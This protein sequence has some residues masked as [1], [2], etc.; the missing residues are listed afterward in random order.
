MTNLFFE[1]TYIKF[2]GEATT[3]WNWAYLRN[4]QCEVLYRFFWTELRNY[5]RKLF[6]C[7]LRR[8]Q[9]VL[10][11]SKRLLT[12]QDV[13]TTSGKRR[14]MCDVLKTFDLDHLEDDQFSMSWRRLIYEVLRTSDL[15]RFEITRFTSSWRRPI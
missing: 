8:L 14:R 4:Q 1:K 7:P 5:N 6:L 12:K 13:V 3:K 15:R 10:K 9:K 2:G 11:R